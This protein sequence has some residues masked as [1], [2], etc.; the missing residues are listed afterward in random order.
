L[1]ILSAAIAMDETVRMKS[2]KMKKLPIVL[3]LYLSN[4]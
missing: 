2:S 4:P 1:R 3:I